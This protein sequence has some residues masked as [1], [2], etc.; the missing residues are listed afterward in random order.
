MNVSNLRLKPNDQ[1]G[2]SLVIEGVLPYNTTEGQLVIDT[3]CNK[4][5]FNLH[6]VI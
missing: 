6:E 3:L 4:D 5:N 1:Y 2:Y